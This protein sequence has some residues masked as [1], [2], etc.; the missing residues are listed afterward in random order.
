VENGESRLFPL[1]SSSSLSPEDSDSEED[2]SPRTLVAAWAAHLRR[3][4][5]FCVYCLLFLPGLASHLTTSL[6][7]VIPLGS[8][9]MHPRPYNISTGGVKKRRGRNWGNQTKA[10]SSGVTLGLTTPSLKEIG[11]G[12]VRR[13]T[14]R[15]RIPQTWVLTS[16]SPNSAWM[17]RSGHPGPEYL[18]I[19]NSC[20]RSG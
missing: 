4:S 15:A 17:E 1:S 7:R 8:L 14:P 12:L 10:S 9:R 2:S 19:V 18:H 6:S 20:H 3:S 16:T 5:Y 13:F 11:L